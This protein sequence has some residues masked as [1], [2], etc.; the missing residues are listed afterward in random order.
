MNNS[1]KQFTK[2]PWVLVTNEA[3][4]IIRPA[5]DEFD[6]VASVLTSSENA[7]LIAAAP[8]LLEAPM[9]RPRVL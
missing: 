2:G 6:Q 3:G 7:R 9:M 5:N 8:E 1:N 4:H